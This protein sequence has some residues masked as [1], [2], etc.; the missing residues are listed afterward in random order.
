KPKPAPAHPER[1]AA[2]FAKP[3]PTSIADLKSIEEQVK[4]LARQL[5]PSVVAVEVGFASG[6]GVVISADGLVLTA[7][8]VCGRPNRLVHFTFSDGKTARGR[9][10]GVDLD[11]DTCLMQITDPGSWPHVAI[12]N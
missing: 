2:V 5:S 1:L 4:V 8:H 9:T 3:V 11:N 7:G 10:L 6:S 12:G